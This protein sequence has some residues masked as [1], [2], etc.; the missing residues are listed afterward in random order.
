MHCFNGIKLIQ[1]K[2]SKEEI[3]PEEDRSDS[4]EQISKVAQR[5]QATRQTCQRILEELVSG[6]IE[7]YLGYR[8]LYSYWRGHNSA[9]PELRQMFRISNIEPDG[10]LSV[11]EEF[12]AQII[13]MAREILTHFS[14]GL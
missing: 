13:S 8:H 7:V 1:K 14:I 12:K 3:G 5:R 11:T 4:L 2:A 6:E 9:V 10:G